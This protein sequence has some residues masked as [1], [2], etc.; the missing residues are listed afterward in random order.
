[1][2]Y[3]HDF[4]GFL[5]ESRENEMNESAVEIAGGIVLGIVGLKVIAGIAKG[6]FGTLKLK[7]MKDPAKLKELAK[8]I[9]G[10]AMEKNPLK[11]ALWNGAVDSMID[12]GDIKD[13]WGLLK[14]AA[15]MDSIDIK[16][17]FESEGFDMSDDVNEEENAED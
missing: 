13:G 17:A 1:M 15:K 16:K 3:V 12:N 11:A 10:R 6:L 5:N 9:A 7:M 4:N 2:K 8:E 14:T